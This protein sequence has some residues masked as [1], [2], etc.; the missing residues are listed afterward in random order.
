MSNRQQPPKTRSQTNAN[1]PSLFENLT[2]ENIDPFKR[3]VKLRHD[4]N[5][6]KDINI[7]SNSEKT[8]LPAISTD[9]HIISDSEKNNLPSASKDNSIIS[10]VDKTNLPSQ[11]VDIRIKTDKSQKA[12]LIQMANFENLDNI[13]NSIPKLWEYKSKIDIY[14]YQVERIQN[15]I[16]P[17]EHDRLF[18]LIIDK[19]DVDGMR[20]IIDNPQLNTWQ[21]L[22]TALKNK[23]ANILSV[24]EAQT[25]ILTTTQ[26]VGE[27][28]KELGERLEENRQRLQ[29]SYIKEYGTSMEI[30]LAKSQERSILALE[31]ALL[32]KSVASKISINNLTTLKEATDYAIRIECLIGSTN[33][34]N[35][36]TTNQSYCKIC[37][38]EGHSTNNCRKLEKLVGQRNQTCSY[39]KNIG[40]NWNECRKRQ[41]RNDFTSQQQNSQYFNNP[42][43][44]YPNNSN[45]FNPSS[46]YV[47]K[48]N[49]N[50]N[51]PFQNTNQ[52]NYQPIN[53][54]NNNNQFSSN[55]R[56]NNTT[57]NSNHNGR[58]FLEEPKTQASKQ[59]HGISL[60]AN[61]FQDEDEYITQG[62][63]NEVM[64]D[65]TGQASHMQSVTAEVH[66]QPSQI[67]MIN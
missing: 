52:N 5:Q 32:N 15:R 51:N 3:S 26:K 44:N 4:E 45:S 63:G 54:N 39:C 49:L 67:N 55:I 46:N 34:V 23:Y 33:R 29:E 6:N 28:I 40:H 47:P 62:S 43:N 56:Q 13:I 18:N 53:R 10:V 36:I 7:I 57:K 21:L 9:I 58:G 17:Q 22:R 60:N 66:V 38:V 61:G 41:F 1:S 30:S 20:L 19:F 35:C 25:Q 50:R 64:R 27:S 42:N 2:Y 24:E 14:I 65:V 59:I 16:E 31:N 37:K 11:T 48:N 8:N 12:T